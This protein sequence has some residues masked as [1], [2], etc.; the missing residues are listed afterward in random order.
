MG[1]SDANLGPRDPGGACLPEHAPPVT[2]AALRANQDPS[3]PSD[4]GI[5]T[6]WVV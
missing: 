1:M 5:G 4:T 3:V 6:R 2:F